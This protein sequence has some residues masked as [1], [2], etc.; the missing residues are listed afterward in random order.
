M[1]DS[2]RG[3]GPKEVFLHLFTIGALYVSVINLL[4]LLF[5]YINRLLPDALETYGYSLK[6]HKVAMSWQERRQAL[7]ELYNVD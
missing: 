2:Q 7:A 4:S 3:N 1:F 5:L 6:H